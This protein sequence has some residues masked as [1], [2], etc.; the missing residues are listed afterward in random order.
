MLIFVVKPLQGWLPFVEASPVVGGLAQLVTDW[1]QG[2]GSVGWYVELPNVGTCTTKNHSKCYSNLNFGMSSR[3]FPGRFNHSSI[4]E[5]M[6]L[7]TLV[8]KHL[9]FL[10]RVHI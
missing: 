10:A 1:L 8:E 9:P 2:D 7:S 5:L 3:N 4:L 6:R